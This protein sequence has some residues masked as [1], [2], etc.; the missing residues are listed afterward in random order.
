MSH[1]FFIRACAG[2]AFQV[3]WLLL[4]TLPAYAATR[5]WLNPV[6]GRW[7]EATNWS[8]GAAPVSG[9]D[10]YITND[11]TFT[12]TNDSG[13]T[14]ATLTLGGGSGT[15]TLSW[16]SGSLSGSTTIGTN[17][18]VNLVGAG[19]KYLYGAIT[20]YGQ[21]VWMSGSG[22]T[23]NWYGASGARLENR[24]GGLLDVQLDGT[25][26]VGSG[27]PVINNAGTF[28]KSV[29]GGAV[30]MTSF[31]F[32]NS[33]LVIVQAGSLTFGSGFTSSGT[34]D[35]T[36]GAAVSLTGG[37]FNFNPGHTFTGNGFYG[38]PVSGSATINGPIINTN[39]QLSGNLTI[40]NELSGTLWWNSGQINGALT[41]ATD[42]SVNLVGAGA[43]YLFGAITNYG[44]VVWTSGSATTWNWY[45]A[46]GARL[47]NR[48]GGLLDVQL[49]GTFAAASGKPVI[50]NAGTF[51]K[52]AGGG[53]LTMNS[54]A[55]TNSGLVNVQA[56]SLTFGSGFTS[57]GTFDVTNGAAVSL[58]GGTFNFNPGHTFTGNG[59]YGVPVSGSATI[60]GP[61]INTNFQLTGNL[62]ITNE[63]S[64]T[65]W[66]NSG[67]INGALTVATDGSVNLV[68]AGAKY[69]FG[70]ITNYGQVVWTS[71]SGTTWNWYGASGARLENCPGGLLDVQL[72]G[73]FTVG[74]GKPV[75]NNAGTFR[76]SAGGGALTM[77]SFAFTNSG[78]VSVQAGSLAFASGFTS[79]G[80][81]DVTNGAAVS[82]MG[83]TFNFNP[84]HTFTGSGFYGV[85]VSGTATI[86]GPI[87]NTN[88]QLAGNL[89]ITNELSG[90]LWWNSGQVNGALTV[91]ANGAVNL[92]GAGAKY[93]FGAITNYGQVVWTSGSAT[94][95]NWYGASGARL[96]NRPGGL[97]DVRLDG[98]FAVGSGAPVINNAGTFRK[99][100]GG[101]TLVISSPFVFGNQGTLQ[102][103]IGTI[104]LP[105]LY[106]ETPSANLAVSLGGTTPGAQYGHIHFSSAPT[107]SG[108]FTVTPRNGFTPSPGN[109]F[110]V[111][112][113][114]SAS[115]NFIAMDG[116]DYGNGLWLE[117]HFAKTGLT[118]TAV[119]L[120]TSTEAALFIYRLPSSLLVSWPIEFTG[121]QLYSTT[122]LAAPVWT[123]ISVA[124]I[125]NTVVPITLPEQYFRLSNP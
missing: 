82:L 19:P 40:T 49:D 54:F 94:T 9:D 8:G 34:F 59:F 24:P 83:G 25:F 12:V 32:T 63:L 91:A 90:T 33:G 50:N 7:A 88:F 57:S 2:L 99:S 95:W 6:S 30:T 69:L 1:Q 102:A 106:S 122:N 80:T 27:T 31:A 104:Q 96:E 74:S 97:L 45:G 123:P 92:V 79:S 78:L 89:T 86:N 14:F 101:G 65:L 109:T 117:P 100:G 62:T 58:M 105:N 87:I 71:G 56:G 52:S 18:A 73:T 125:N 110:Y 55:F 124:G 81:F 103:Q 116:L 112:S 84:G 121:Y 15:Q 4:A 61:I 118:L 76:K 68:G 23:W 36:N 46:S 66:W 38:V 70:A 108:R 10:V 60:N 111:L 120:P 16:S 48:P 93:L 115:G 21:V 98:T 5:V 64:G 37:T 53:A 75:I 22:T 13:A 67:Q 20:N 17:G 35:V 44:Q 114:P 39:F 85:P 41:V 29:G 113:Y 11:G 3:V 26:A 107:F 47:E 43:K 51:R 77:N 72:D 119:N 42:G 28:R